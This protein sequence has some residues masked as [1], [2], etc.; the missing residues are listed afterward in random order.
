MVLPNPSSCKQENCSAVTLQRAI[1]QVTGIEHD[2]DTTYG[3]CERLSSRDATDGPKGA[4]HRV[5]RHGNGCGKGVAAGRHNMCVI[6]AYGSGKLSGE[7]K[8]RDVTMTERAVFAGTANRKGQGILAQ[9]CAALPPLWM[10]YA[11]ETFSNSAQQAGSARRGWV[12]HAGEGTKSV[13][14][15][16][17]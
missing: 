3:I 11:I 15:A 10:M 12:A 1:I 7:F 4:P 5:R 8:P 6:R 17:Q 14:H 2:M 9:G 16:G 13:C